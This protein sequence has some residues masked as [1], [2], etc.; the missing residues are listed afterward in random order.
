VAWARSVQ[1]HIAHTKVGLVW[2][3]MQSSAL[4][5]HLTFVPLATERL[6]RPGWLC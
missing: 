4:P 5:S 2:Q 6:P 3:R 1:P